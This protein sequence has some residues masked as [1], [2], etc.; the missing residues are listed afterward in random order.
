MCLKCDI[1][2]DYIKINRF[3]GTHGYVVRKEGA[4]KLIEFLDKPLSKQIDADLS[5]L[6][7][8]N[9]I[10]VYGINPI[11]VAQDPKFGS[12]IQESVKES[13]EAFEEEFKQRQLDSIQA[14]IIIDKT[15]S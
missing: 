12:D 3:W 13:D 2:K 14:K 4:K 10:K 7:K 1:E 15:Y 5:L 8:R 11:I 9:L 6:I